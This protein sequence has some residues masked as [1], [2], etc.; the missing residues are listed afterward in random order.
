[1]TKYEVKEMLGSYYRACRDLQDIKIRIDNFKAKNSTENLANSVVEELNK[2]LEIALSSADKELA[3]VQSYINLLNNNDG[4]ATV[5]KLYHIEG[6]SE[7]EIAKKMSLSAE[8]IR[9]KRW[10]AYQKIADILG[11]SA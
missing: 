6:L 11:E 9:T 3:S 1:M 5:L 4:N 2:K 7:K 10:R 8:Y